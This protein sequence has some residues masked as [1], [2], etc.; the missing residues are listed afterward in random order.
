MLQQLLAPARARWLFWLAIV[1]VSILAFMPGAEVPV[2]T[3]WDKSNHALAFFV[4]ALLAVCSWPAASVWQRCLGL[5]AYGVLIECVQ[6][7]VGRDAAMLDIF[8]DA[9]GIAIGQ[10]VILLARGQRLVWSR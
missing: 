10:V 5:L 4:L 1:G 9:V 6:Y 3:G 8:A 2:S 7:V